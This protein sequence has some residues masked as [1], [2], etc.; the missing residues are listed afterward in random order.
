VDLDLWGRRSMKVFTLHHV[1]LHQ[2]ETSV[3]LGTPRY[4]LPEGGVIRTPPSSACGIRFFSFQAA[5]QLPVPT[6]IPVPVPG[7]DRG[8]I[9][10]SMRANRSWTFHCRGTD[11][12]RY[13]T[14][15]LRCPSPQAAGI[16]PAP[17]KLDFF[18]CHITFRQMRLLGRQCTLSPSL[19]FSCTDV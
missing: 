4:S 18:L 9:V 3:T 7:Y 1:S 5:W 10:A 16:S 2:R 12:I 14:D 17:G 6:P 13:N 19:S 11:Q 15:L 8:F